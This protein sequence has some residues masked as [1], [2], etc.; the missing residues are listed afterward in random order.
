[1]SFGQQTKGLLH[2]IT[3]TSHEVYHIFNSLGFEVFEGPQMDSS[4]HNFDDVNVPVEHPARDMQDTFY[5]EGLDDMVM[6]THTSNCQVP[7]L[8]ANSHRL[9][10]GPLKMISLG[11]VFRSEATD[12][13][14]ERQFYQVEGVMVGK[15]VGLGHLK[16]TLEYFLK[17]F[18]RKDQV[19]MRLRPS[20]FPF[21]EPGVEIDL[22]FKGKFIELL[23]AGMIHPNVLKRAKVDSDIYTG[24]AFGLGIDRATMIRNA[25]GDVRYSYNGDLRLHFGLQG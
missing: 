6:R 7:Y 21:V 13:T 5:I 16:G 10:F 25:I 4:I 19:N 15:G 9:S 18:M 3:T 22:D 8:Q 12:A 17:K 1:M 11:K 23:G 14:H 2:P 20:Y 24:F